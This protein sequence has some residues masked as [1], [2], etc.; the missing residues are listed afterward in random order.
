MLLFVVRAAL[1]KKKDAFSEVTP[2]RLAEIYRHCYLCIKFDGD[3]L[4]L[5][6]ILQTP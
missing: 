6:T 4:P 2:F 5:L 3:Y 1:D